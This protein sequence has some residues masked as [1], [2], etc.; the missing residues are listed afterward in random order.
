MTTKT[1]NVECAEVTTDGIFILPS[2]VPADMPH[3]E[4]SDDEM[5]VWWG[6]PFIMLNGSYSVYRFDGGAWTARRS[7]AAQR[8]STAPSRSHAAS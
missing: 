6:R 7:A 2:S 1:A 3:D 5:R 8:R 4:R